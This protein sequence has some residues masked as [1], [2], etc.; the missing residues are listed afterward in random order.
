M[1][2]PTKRYMINTKTKTIWAYDPNAIRLNDNLVEC[3]EIGVPI[4]RTET[5]TDEL[6]EKIIELEGEIAEKNL[7]IS[8]L[9]S[10]LA[11]VEAELKA[12]TVN[13]RKEA[14]GEMTAPELRKL[15]ETLGVE[16]P[17]RAN[18]AEIVDAV[19]AA[20]LMADSEIESGDLTETGE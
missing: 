3:N 10:R 18:K 16:L 9:E 6:Y 1:E 8:A 11:E 15:A 17:A 7:R 4:G 19:Y 12:A 5:V 2:K 20:E 14:L 13:P